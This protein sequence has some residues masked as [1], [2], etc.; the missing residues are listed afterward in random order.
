MKVIFPVFVEFRS[1][2][3]LPQSYHP[4]RCNNQ[5]PEI[6][7][8]MLLF[9]FDSR[10]AHLGSKLESNSKSGS[11]CT[12]SAVHFHNTIYRCLL[13]QGSRYKLQNTAHKNLNRV[14]FRFI[15]R[16]GPQK[17]KKKK[18]MPTKLQKRENNN[19]GQTNLICTNW[20]LCRPS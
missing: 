13:I 19:N 1:A 4:N 11:S 15:V 5:W 18:K 14:K 12:A 3:G 8:S 20:M 17:S 10:L 7:K 2:P 9:N 6:L 16:T